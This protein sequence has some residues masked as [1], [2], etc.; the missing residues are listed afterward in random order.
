MHLE[1]IYSKPHNI[2][3][4]Y[5]RYNKVGSYFQFNCTNVLDFSI[6]CCFISNYS[7]K[8]QLKRSVHTLTLHVNMMKCQNTVGEFKQ[9]EF[10][11]LISNILM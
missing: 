5:N 2:Y 10:L 7:Q 6:L 8:C 11:C 9:R 4:F 3:G 1:L